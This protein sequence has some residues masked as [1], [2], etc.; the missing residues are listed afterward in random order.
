VSEAVTQRPM[1]TTLA[2]IKEHNPCADGWLKLLEHLGKT[3]A[4]EEPLPYL[5][6]LESNGLEDALWACRAEPRYDREWRLYAVWCAEQVSHLMTDARSHAALQVARRFANGE[7]TRE[8]LD[9]AGA[10]ARAAG[11]AWGDAWAAAWE[12]AGAAVWAAA[13][14]PAGAVTWDVARA[15]VWAA[16]WAAEAAVWAAA[17]AAGAAARDAAWHAAGAAARAAGDAWGDARAAARAAEAARAAAR[18]AQKA[19]FLRVVGSTGGD[20]G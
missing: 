20:R 12:A 3:E 9:A 15:A 1:T 4:D 18:D 2:R 19:E 11:D 13:L 6:I 14:T 5:V 17:W 8:E 7:A 16:A 10:A